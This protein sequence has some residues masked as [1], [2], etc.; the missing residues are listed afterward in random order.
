MVFYFNS[1]KAARKKREAEAQRISDQIDG[2]LRAERAALGKQRIVKILPL[3]Q[4]ESGESHLDVH[5]G[6]SFR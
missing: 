6:E 4:S 2:E 1:E 3:G 5:P